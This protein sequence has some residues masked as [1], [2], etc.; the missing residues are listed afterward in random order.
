VRDRFEQAPA[1]APAMI[2]L[3]AL[4][5]DEKDRQDFLGQVA[6]SFGD[7]ACSEETARKIDMAVAETVAPA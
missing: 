1:K 7:K 4:G 2:F 6:P 3:D 5:R